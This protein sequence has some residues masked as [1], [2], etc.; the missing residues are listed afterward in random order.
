MNFYR[1]IVIA[2]LCAGCASTPTKSPVAA[3]ASVP[4]VAPASNSAAPVIAPPV[5]T[6]QQTVASV[7]NSTAELA[8]LRSTYQPSV[9]V[10]AAPASKPSL[11]KFW[12]AKT[13]SEKAAPVAATVPVKSTTNTAKPVKSHKLI[14]WLLTTILAVPLTWAAKKYG[15]PLFKKFLAWVKSKNVVT[16]LKTLAGEA[17]SKLVTDFKD[18]EADF[19]KKPA[20]AAAPVVVGQQTTPPTLNVHTDPHPA[21]T[22]EKAFAAA[23]VKKP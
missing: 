10:K 8:A 20:V 14:Y 5:P 16:D 3:P 13:P 17:E 1:Y 18:V 9:P 12:V 23:E 21:T 19:S 15:M 6:S 7:D 4:V 22:A 2:A 11:L